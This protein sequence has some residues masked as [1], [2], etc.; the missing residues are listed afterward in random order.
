MISVLTWTHNWQDMLD[1]TIPGW[2]MQQDVDFEIIIGHSSAIVIP[3]HPK[4]KGVLIEGKGKC[5]AYNKL[6]DAASGDLLLLTQIDMQVNS[7]TQL[8][9]MLDKWE[10][11]VAVTERFF[12]IDRRV[13]GIFLQCMLVE[14]SRVELAGKCCE[15]YDAPSMYAYEDSDLSASLQETGV[16]IVSIDTP[17]ED[18]VYHLPHKKVDLSD[19]VIQGRMKN[20]HDLYYSRHKET[21][22]MNF[23]RSQVKYLT[24]GK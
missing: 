5:A 21:V 1:K 19:P 23:I 10:P 20:A 6:I 17:M 13:N 24:R 3:T 15:D 18:G 16:R 9:R 8:K 22:G 4:I 11:G 12:N 7:K 2:L 14:K